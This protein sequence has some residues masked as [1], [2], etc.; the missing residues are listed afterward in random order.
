M[1]TLSEIMSDPP[2]KNAR[3]RAAIERVLTPE[4]QQDGPCWVWD[5]Y[6]EPAGYAH[7]PAVSWTKSRRL[8]RQVM[9]L[10]HGPIEPGLDV[11]HRCDNRACYRPSHLFLGTRLDNM[12]DMA[13]KGRGYSTANER[14]HVYKLTNAEVAEIRRL[15]AEGWSDRDLANRFGCHQSYI[16]RLRRHVYRPAEAVAS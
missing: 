7:P 9:A 5:G 4:A 15:S 12:R 16:C 1:S 3:L 14:S 10:L 13:E 6:I 8:H 11:C 2:I